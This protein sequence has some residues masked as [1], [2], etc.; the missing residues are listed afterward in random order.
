MKSVALFL[1]GVFV[2]AYF[3]FPGVGE[4]ALLYIDPDSASVYRGDTVTLNLRLDTDEGECINTVDAVIEYGEGVRAIDVSRGDSILNLWVEDPKINEADRTISF[5]GGITGGYCG[6][7]AG[8]P[9]LTNVIAQIVFQSPGFTVGG[10]GNSPTVQISIKDTTS[11][12]LNDG[13]GTPAPLRMENASI[14]LQSTA[15]SERTDSWREEVANDTIPPGDF[16][17]TLASDIAAFSGQ[18]FINW[19]TQD[20]QSGIDHYEVM[21]EPLEDLYAFRWGRVD[22]PWVEAES[23]YVLKDQT[24][25]STIRV[26]A[27]DKAGNETIAVLVPDPALRSL[28]SNRMATMALIGGVAVILIAIVVYALLERRRRILTS[29]EHVE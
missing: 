2:S 5:A 8:D 27:I 23:P 7:A 16:A 10:G 1:S 28:S 6:R 21:E 19:N 15:G 14:Q 4:A 24:L 11:V 26:K 18:Y 25:N 20:K 9:S 13:F 22:A 17:I 29:Y 3:L 12:L